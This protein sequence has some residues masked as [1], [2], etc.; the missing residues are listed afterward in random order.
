MYDMRHQWDF[1][2][3]RNELYST[4]MPVGNVCKNTIAG[5]L[6]NTPDLSI[7]AKIVERARM[8]DYLNDAFDVQKHTMFVPSDQYLLKLHPKD[9]FNSIDIGVARSLVTFALMKGTI[10]KRYFKGGPSSQFVTMN[11]VHK[12]FVTNIS[13]DT[14]LSKNT[15]VIHWNH[16]VDNGVIHVTDNLL[17]P[18]APPCIF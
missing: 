15:R 2:D 18:D 7:F 1:V 14:I 3:L 6:I 17:D 16:M 13:D 5:M 8:M 11:P 10:T 4:S 9:Y 12:L